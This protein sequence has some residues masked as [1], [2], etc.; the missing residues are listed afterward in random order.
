MKMAPSW[1]APL[2]ASVAAGVLL[3][4]GGAAAQA[5]A[6]APKTGATEVETIIV[7][8]EKRSTN[9]QSTPLTVQALTENALKA[10]GAQSVQN[11][12]T[13]VPGLAF[14]KNFSN[15]TPYLRGVGQN[16]GTPNADSPVAIY[17][18][19]VYLAQPASGMFSFNNIQQIEVAKGP[20]GTLFGRN[21]TGGVIQVTTRQ[22]SLETSSKASIGYGNYDTFQGDA[23]VTGQVAPN[24]ASSLAAYGYKRRDGYI[25]NLFLHSK[26]GQREDYG[27]QSKTLWTPDDKTD[28]TLNLIYNWQ[29][30][31]IGTTTG[32][33]PGMVAD[34]H[35]TRYAGQ[36]AVYDGIPT[37]NRDAQFLGAMTANHDFGWATL[38]S[39]S[40]YHRM[41]DR[42]N[43]V[44]NAEPIH[45][46]RIPGVATITL[47][48]PTYGETYTQEFQLKSPDQQDFRW[49]LGAFLLRDKTQQNA[50]DFREGFFQFQ[51]SAP[52]IIRGRQL[53]KSYAGYAE[54]SKTVLPDTRLTL[55]VRYTQDKKELY[56]QIATLL[57]TGAILMSSPAAP[58]GTFRPLETPK[59]WDAFTYRAVLDHHFTPDIMGYVS[60]NRGFKSGLYNIAVFFNPPVNPETINAYE[61]GLKSEF[62][63]HRLRLNVAA[64]DYDYKNIQLRQ[65]GGNFPGRF[66]LV[67]AATGTVRGLDVDFTAVPVRNLTLTGGFEVLDAMYDKFPG[68]PFAFP[69]PVTLP[70]P[71]GCAVV[72]ALPP[73]AA[74]V[75]GNTTATCDAS[76]TR[77]IRSPKFTGN[78]GATYV[79][80]LAGGDQLTF[81]A[82]DHYNSGFFWDPDHLLKQKS[83]HNAAASL[84]WTA[85]SGAWDVG[86]WGTNLFQAHIW[87]SSTAGPTS[88]F[89]PGEPRQFGIRASVRR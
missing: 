33:Y 69:N 81:S 76:N 13:L 80:D 56:G 41:W 1:K 63:D 73:S 71:A 52:N 24:V 4:A 12:E 35:V 72:G 10:A 7:T 58:G 66:I 40:A 86:I 43:F 50:D 44:Q 17:V 8:A 84:T 29:R 38:T 57:P 26:I 25:D 62:F 16:A 45:T 15:G 6:G 14:G 68:A 54:A 64:F 49:I 75:G 27:I 37:P 60:F 2:M 20:Q 32:V 83:Y 23:Y 9:L 88:T 34:D 77:M 89:S 39:I 51:G 70:L 82:N 28:V 67:N 85:P 87:A 21:T 78:I 74:L 31:Y 47:F 59:T 65:T 30:T 36:Y 46:P 55:G 19:G 61:V 48:I 53:T 18:D 42:L 5:S 79:H 11:L 22:P 3:A